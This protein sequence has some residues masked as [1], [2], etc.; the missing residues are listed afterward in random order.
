MAREIVL[1]LPADKGAQPGRPRRAGA[2]FAREHFVSRGLAVQLDV[3]APHG[4]ESEGERANH[5][6]HLLITTRRLVEGGLAAKKARD[7]DPVTSRGGAASDGRRGLGRAVGGAPEPLLRRAWPRRPGRGDGGGA[8]GAHRA[9]PHAAP[10]AVANR[11]AEEIRRERAAARDPEKVLRVLTRNNAIF[12]MRARSH[13]A[14]HIQDEAEHLEVKAQVLGRDEVLALYDPAT[15]EGA[16]AGRRA[17][18]ARRN[19]RRWTMAA[20][21]RRG[22][23]R[24]L[25]AGV[26]ERRVSG[27]ELRAD[28]RA[29]LDHAAARAV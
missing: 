11:R 24:A 28:Q 25:G 27:A 26:R 12:R 7:L 15:G 20:R 1:A 19:A 2:S 21:G 3:H 8:A 18:S 5:H 29:A 16:G 10:E 17:R 22:A 9:D 13:L 23:H 14:K 6:A 4:A